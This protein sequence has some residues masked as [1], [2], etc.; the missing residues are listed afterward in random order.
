MILS[1]LLKTAL[2]RIVGLAVGGMLL[3]GILYAG[4]QV[5]G[6]ITHDADVK[7]KTAEKTLEV[8]REDRKIKDE[9]RQMDDDDLA[10]FLRRGGVRKD[11]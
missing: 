2:G 5:K 11:R 1:W 10:N 6:C 9:V 4:C 8:E 3:S 7:A